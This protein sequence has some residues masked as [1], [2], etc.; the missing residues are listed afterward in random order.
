LRRFTVTVGLG[1][2]AQAQVRDQIDAL[3]RTC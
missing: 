1:Q 3:V 2:G